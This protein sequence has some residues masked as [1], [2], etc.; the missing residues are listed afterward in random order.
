MLRHFARVFLCGIRCCSCFSVLDCL[1]NYGAVLRKLNPFMKRMGQLQS[2]EDGFHKEEAPHVQRRPNQARGR[3][4]RRRFERGAGRIAKTDI[5]HG[6]HKGAGRRGW[7]QQLRVYGIILP[8][9]LTW[10][11]EQAN[12]KHKYQPLETIRYNFCN[13]KTTQATTMPTWR[14]FTNQRK[15]QTN[16]Q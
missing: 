5:A 6:V 1:G 11:N 8:N 4:Q 14:P 12:G 10:T 2:A 3:I 15:W 16:L 9:R 13:S 7:T